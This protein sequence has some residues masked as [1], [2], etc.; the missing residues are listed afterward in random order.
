LTSKSEGSVSGE[1]IS[2]DALSFIRPRREGRPARRSPALLL[3]AF[4]SACSSFRYDPNPPPPPPPRADAWQESTQEGKLAFEQ[5][6]FTVAEEKL[7]E[8]QTVSK[9]NESEQLTEATSLANL[10][11][12]RR[13]QGDDAGAQALYERCL[14]IR[15]KEL[16]PDDPEVLQTL[17]NLAAVY[18]ARENYAAAE[19]LFRR[20]LDSREKTLGPDDRH[21]AQSMNNLALLYAAQGR[22]DEAEPLYERSLA[23]LEKSVGRNHP[24]I[25]KVLE[26]YAALL[27]ETGRA[28]RSRELEE[29]AHAV[30]R[31]NEWSDTRS[32]R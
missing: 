21:T 17:N 2:G 25:A 11:V 10:A 7:L 27:A 20:V 6:R 18:G 19:P 24:D 9:R 13:A 28:E 1:P 29:R 31:L 23:A 26:N 5:G 30:V 8:A 32:T 15:E 4:S 3:L 14:G 16:G 22:Y 12:V